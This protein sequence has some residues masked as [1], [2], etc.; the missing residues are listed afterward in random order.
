MR[1]VNPRAV[2]AALICCAIAAFAIVARA[3]VR[4]NVDLSA[5]R[6]HVESQAGSF[7]FPISSART[8]FN[9]PRGVY[10]AQRLVRMHYSKKYHNSPMPH[11]IFFRGGYAIH[12]TGYVGQLGR[13]ASHGCIRL[14]PRNAATLYRL[15]QE[16]GARIAITGAPPGKTKIA[17]ARLGH[18]RTQLAW[19]SHRSH[20]RA[21]A[22][23][24]QYSGFGRLSLRWW[25]LHPDGR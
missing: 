20:G 6:M 15:V 11:S 1:Q 19:R 12:G 9:T 16:E 18:K 8:G 13:P 24:P 22:Y 4:V 21:L 3:T 2:Q 17:K 23:A 25:L 7:D 5:Q 10:R 14:S